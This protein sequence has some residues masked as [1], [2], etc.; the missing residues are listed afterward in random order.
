MYFL[1][2]KH[3]PASLQVPWPL[4]T[5]KNHRDASTLIRPEPA[6]ELA[7]KYKETAVPNHEIKITIDTLNKHPRSL[8]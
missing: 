4:H 1:N 2:M 6:G 3:Y 5:H 7:R 8:Q